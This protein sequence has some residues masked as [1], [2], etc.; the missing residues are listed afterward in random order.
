[1]VDC[2]E[3]DN[4][5]NGGWMENAYFYAFFYPLMNDSAY[6]YI[7]REG[8]CRDNGTGKYGIRNYVNVRNNSPSSMKRAVA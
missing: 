3:F 8:P 2:D 4:G 5:C 1:M 7:N 6:P